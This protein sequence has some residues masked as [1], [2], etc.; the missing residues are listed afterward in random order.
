MKD[1]LTDQVQQLMSWAV[2]DPEDCRRVAEEML[3]RDPNAPRERLARELVR[4]A[5]KQAA[6]VG[7][8][9]GLVA[10]P[11][12]MLPA[13][14]ADI[15][16]VLKIE[17]TMVGGVAALLDPASLNDPER[18]R[19]DVLAV[20]F[21][22]AASQALRQIGMRAGEQFTKSLIRRSAGK[23]G[24]ETLVKLAGKLLGTQLTGKAL[25]TKSVP[26][27]GLGIGAGWNWLEA[28][29]VG[30]R[31]MKYHTG[32]PIGE[33]K[34]RALGRRFLPERWRAKLSAAR[35]KDGKSTSPDEPG[36]HSS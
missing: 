17:G 23:G 5:Q 27:V 9:T 18:F 33:E 34:L 4:Y 1:F 29:A 22:A 2:P 28:S 3:A 21:P 6:A 30:S 11:V 32:H 7:G 25:A 15:A 12:A 13:A 35:T 10:S 8:V 14:L 36:G 26:L 20:V 16:A 19:T 31:A 24:L